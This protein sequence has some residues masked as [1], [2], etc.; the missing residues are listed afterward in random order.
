[1]IDPDI[2]DGLAAGHGPFLDAGCGTLVFTAAAYQASR[3]LVL[4]DRSLGMLRRAAERLEGAP[5]ALVQADVLDLP[6]APGRFATVACHAMLHVLDDPWAE[7]AA[8]HRQVAPGG[9]LFASMLV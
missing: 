8:L 9:R 2:C 7:L 4:V 5:A 1:M 6:F 3:P